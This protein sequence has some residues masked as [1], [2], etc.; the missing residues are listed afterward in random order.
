MSETKPPVLLVVDGTALAFRAFFAVRGLTDSQGRPSGALYGYLSSLLRVLDEHPAERVVVAWDR[1]EP[2]F[3]HRLSAEYK[4]T[5]ERMD[6]DL[7]AQ[8]PW[9]RE[10]TEL[11]GLAQLDQAGFEAD[12]ILATLAAQGADAGMQV[13]LCAG[14]KDLAQVVSERVIMVPPPRRNEAS[15]VL[16][17]PEIEE[18]F[19]VPPAQMAEWQ[20][21]VG[22]SS[23][24]VAGMPGVGP[25]KA[26]ILLAKYGSLTAVLERGPQEEK[27]KLRE[28]LEA[29]G[30][31]VRAALELVTLRTDMEL[32]PLEALD[33]S[34]PDLDGIRTFCDE[35]SFDSLMDRMLA[36]AEPSGPSPE[37]AAAARDY[38]LVDT[39][40]KLRA[41]RDG[42]AASGGFAVDTETTGLDPM[43]ALLV[44]VSFSWQD[45]V[46]WYLP[47]NLQPPLAGP[48]GE[49][50]LDY[51]LPV[52]QD[53]AVPKFGQ[54]LKYDAHVLARHGAEVRGWE[55]DTMVAHFLA[56]PLSPHNLDAMAL[57]YLG[58]RKIATES[59]IGKGKEQTT[60]D[61]L[62]VEDVA[63]YACEDADATWRLVA[64]LRAAL[65]GT[66]EERLF[67]EVEMPL[68]DVL[69][70]MEANGVRVDQE[71]LAEM[72]KRLE[73]REAELEGRV[74]EL[75]GDVFNLNS[76]KQLGPVLFEKLQIQEQAGVKRVRKTKTGYA[77]SAPALE[78]YHGVPIV[79]ALL[80]YRH[81]SKLRGTY[82]EALPGYV[83]PQTGCIH[84]SFHQAVAS[85]GRL[86]SSDPNL[87]NIPIRTEAGREI[88]RAFVPKEDGWLLVSADYSQIELRIVAH[89]AGDP[90]LAQAF[91]DGADVHARTAALVFDVPQEEVTPEMRSR[92]KAINFGILYGMGPARLSR[93]LK[94][95]F[96]EARKFIDAY[97]EALPGVRGWLDATLDQAREEGEVRTLLG[98]RRP[99]P[100]LNS[101]DARVRASAE[102]VAVN[103]PVQGSAADLIKVAMIR[104]DQRLRREGLA[105]RMLLQVHDELVFD[106][107]RAELE[108]LQALVREEMEGVWQLDVPLQV[109]IGHGPD[110]ASAH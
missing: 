65:T 27:G 66:E 45:E 67:R 102:N 24:N 11:L 10:G 21:L 9:M 58:L 39:P 15:V 61:L 36:G 6:E 40:E 91:R 108:R 90:A 87:Q 78:P 41:L 28:N 107:P 3:R 81:L 31:Q 56:D 105:A 8:L 46:A 55:F 95:S 43:R 94:I 51:L 54:N 110:W 32:G 48:D 103:T 50:P 1:P 93:E 12:D 88:R 68:V 20:A 49:A 82:V 101:E 22:D 99:V 38:R 64:P 35:H 44:G 72:R 79:D 104:V 52:L 59:L 23:D 100:E 37:E 96:A 47:M 84:T 73:R 17:P 106:C 13:K 109:E 25:K 70:R 2:T 80:E 85:T 33:R 60:M 18:K 14:D 26:T 89:L 62:P 42:L 86:S 57:R 4:A 83:H 53:E 29:Y 75:A 76:P 19:G 7:A 34:D 63:R 74:H 69:R 16:G 71:R 77:T 97:F 30:D 98:R 92:S 5:R